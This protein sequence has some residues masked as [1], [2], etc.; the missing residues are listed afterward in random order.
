MLKKYRE[1]NAIFILIFIVQLLSESDTLKEIF[2]FGNV[3][4]FVKPAITLSL[5]LLLLFRTGLKGRFAKRIGLGLFFGL[6]GD[7]MLM[8]PDDQEL[9]F[10][11]GLVAFLIGHIFYI[12]AFYLDYS[13]NKDLHKI[14]TKNAIIAYAFYTVLFCVGLFSHL[15]PLKIPVAIYGVVISVMGVMAVNRFGRVSSQSFKLVFVGSL[16]FVLSD[17]VL[18]INKFAYDFKG[19]GFIIMGTY[20]LAQYAIT[21]GGIERKIKKKI[22]D[23]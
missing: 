22:E 18:A 17:S 8:L 12:L 11:L 13:L 15:G 7:V 4:F 20:M 6:V 1:F 9:F 19:S 2:L 10:T 23:I 16:L 5:F 3:H 21:I 14:Y